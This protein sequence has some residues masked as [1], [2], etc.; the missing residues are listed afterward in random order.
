MVVE[1]HNTSHLQQEILPM[2]FLLSALNS[3]CL[4]VTYPTNI[5]IH[6]KISETSTLFYR[7]R[8]QKWKLKQHVVFF[9]NKIVINNTTTTTKGI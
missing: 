7:T 9:G 3:P 2:I 1:G 8:K 6:K 4:H 5:L